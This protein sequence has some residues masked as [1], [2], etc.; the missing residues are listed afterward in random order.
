MI[1]LDDEKLVR[2]VDKGDMYGALEGFVEQC[3]EAITIAG[4]VDLSRFKGDFTSIMVLGMGGSGVSGNLASDVLKGELDI[5][6]FVNKSYD[7]G[8]FVGPKTLVFAVSYS[9]NTEETL[10]AFEAAKAKGA[11]IISITSGGRLAELT[12]EAG[13]PLILVPAGYQPRAALGYLSF[14]ILVSLERLGIV[15]SLKKDFEDL[16]ERL[17][18]LRREFAIGSTLGENRAKQLAKRIL[19]KMPVI[20]GSSGTTETIALRWKC[21]INENSK[22]P[23]FYSIFPELNHNETVG[24]E[25]LKDI[26]ERFYLIIFKDEDDHPQVKSRID[27]TESLIQ[28]QFDGSALIWT[29]GESKLEKIVTTIYLGDYVSFYIAIMEGID[30]SPVDRIIH[31]KRMLEEAAKD[32]TTGRSANICLAEE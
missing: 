2:E 14:P 29:K 32:R 15:P 25:L 11:K 18:F 20:Y 24:W 17:K 30:P 19:G 26:T 10:S 22:N 9:G 4:R 27:I 28:E 1:N 23:A 31:L 13:F 12:K 3:E 5:P 7:I 6:I 21:Q 16:I 8:N